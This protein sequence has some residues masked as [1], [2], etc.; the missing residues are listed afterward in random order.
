MIEQIAKSSGYETFED[1]VANVYNNNV[2]FIIPPYYNSKSTVAFDRWVNEVIPKIQEA[3]CK[4]VVED[5]VVYLVKLVD[6][7]DKEE[8]NEVLDEEIIN[9]QLDDE[10]NS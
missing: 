4:L 3:K 6:K 7:V 2:V 8:Y 10:N 9:V 1:M 5:D